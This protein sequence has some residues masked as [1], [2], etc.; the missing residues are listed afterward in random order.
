MKKIF[1]LVFAFCLCNFAM[2][3]DDQDQPSDKKLQNIEALKAAFLSKELELTPEEA[4]KFWPVYNQYEKELKATILQ[5]DE[6]IIERDE[7][8][9]AIRKRYKDEFTRVLGDKRMNRMFS[10]EVRFRGML[11]KAMKQK[12]NRQQ[13]RQQFRQN[14][15]LQRNG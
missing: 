9:L 3:Q 10:A 8:V 12:Q 6:N 15:P 14:K 11:I 13:N 4:Q 7:K 2:A 1:T 5:H